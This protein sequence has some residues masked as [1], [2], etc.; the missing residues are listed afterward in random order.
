MVGKYFSQERCTIDLGPSRGL[1]GTWLIVFITILILWTPNAHYFWHITGEND[2]IM[3]G[4]FFHEGTGF[5]I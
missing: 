4:I 2:K 5:V 3:M 1:L